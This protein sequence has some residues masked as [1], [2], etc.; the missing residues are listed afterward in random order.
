MATVD[1]KYILKLENLRNKLR[2][3]L[4]AKGIT[5]A[6]DAPLDKLV[7]LTET[8]YYINEENKQDNL[9]KLLLGN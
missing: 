4:V 7:E 6:E 9:Y 3:S 8:K 1:D 5:V 2:N